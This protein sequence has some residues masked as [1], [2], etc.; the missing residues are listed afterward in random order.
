MIQVPWVEWVG[1]AASFFVAVSLIMTSIVKLRILN[2]IGC[3][4]FVAYAL[5]IGA[6]PVFITNAA[7][8]LINIWNLYRLKAKK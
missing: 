4:L 3:A 8:I 2:T 5:L 6:Y 1:Y 7:I